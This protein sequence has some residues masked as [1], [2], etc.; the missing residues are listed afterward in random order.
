MHIQKYYILSVHGVSM[1]AT[2]EHMICRHRYERRAV[3]I[4]PDEIVE[5]CTKCGKERVRSV[6][7]SQ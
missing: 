2:I 7:G 3:V 4:D 5:S 6:A 1:H